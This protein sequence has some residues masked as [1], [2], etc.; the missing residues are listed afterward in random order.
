MELCRTG[1]GREM[2]CYHYRIKSTT[3]ERFERGYLLQYNI[4]GIA[5]VVSGVKDE[6][7]WPES[8]QNTEYNGA[9]SP[10]RRIQLRSITYQYLFLLFISLKKEENKTHN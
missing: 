9:L 6:Q 2:G 3:N 4:P 1:S 7:E 10:Q 8:Y 5:A